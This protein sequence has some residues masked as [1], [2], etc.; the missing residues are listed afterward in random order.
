MLNVDMCMAY[1]NNPLHSAC[2]L[3]NGFKNKICKSK[4]NKGKSILAQTSNGC[5]AWTNKNALLRNKVLSSEQGMNICGKELTGQRK[6]DRK[7]RFMNNREQ[8]CRNEAN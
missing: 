7:F 8:C 3:K 5:C 4:Q 1:D 2:M 6:I